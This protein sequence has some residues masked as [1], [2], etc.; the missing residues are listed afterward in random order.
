MLTPF[1]RLTFTEHLMNEIEKADF[2]KFTAEAQKYLEKTQTKQAMYYNHQLKLV[3]I[4]IGDKV[5]VKPYVL[6][7]AAKATVANF[8]QKYQGPHEVIDWIDSIMKIQKEGKTQN[9]HQV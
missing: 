2:D 5:L 9:I 8:A 7:S 4:N 6:R 3:K 1:E